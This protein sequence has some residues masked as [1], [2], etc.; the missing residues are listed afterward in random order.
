M[1]TSLL[2]F[3]DPADF[4]S[5]C[6]SSGN[7]FRA[8][9]PRRTWPFGHDPDPWDDAKHEMEHEHFCAFA[10][11][12]QMLRWFPSYPDFRDQGLALSL[13]QVSEAIV[14]PSQA[15][16]HSDHYIDHRRIF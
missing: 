9:I 1:Q 4:W 6:Y 11:C 16:F 5:G 14:L 7:V 3:H 10:S 8:M 2:R 12:R 13:V 15:I